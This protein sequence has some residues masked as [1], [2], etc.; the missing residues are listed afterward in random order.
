M[1]SSRTSLG[2]ICGERYSMARFPDRRGR[3]LSPG[4]KIA[5]LKDRA[6]S[7]GINDLGTP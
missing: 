6:R 3:P 2:I 1:S 5:Q 7:A 4:E